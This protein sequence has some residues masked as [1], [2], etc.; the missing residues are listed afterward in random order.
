MLEQPEEFR[1]GGRAGLVGVGEREH[2]TTLGKRRAGQI[3]DDIPTE[4]LQRQ[5]GRSVYVIDIVRRI[6]LLDSHAAKRSALFAGYD[7]VTEMT[8]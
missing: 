8:S 2:T 6:V 3:A 1:A 4:R 5:I 7:L